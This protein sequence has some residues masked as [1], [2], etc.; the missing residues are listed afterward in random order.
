MK[1]NILYSLI[2][3]FWITSANTQELNCQ[4]SVTSDPALDVTT[5]EKEV[6]SQLEQTIFELVNT[7]AWTKDEFEVEER[8]NC[9]MVIS[10]IKV[11]SPGNYEATLQVQVSRPVFNTSYNTTLFN[12]LDENVQFSFERNAILVYS[13]NQFR[14]NLTSIIAFYAYMI[15]GYDYDSFALNGG[16]EHFR[17]AQEIVMLA[18]SGGGSGWR[19]NERG[20]K[21]RY[22]LVDNA[23]QELFSPLRECFYEYHRKGLDKM[24]DN[25]EEARNNMFAAIE[26]LSKV[27]TARPGSV[28]VLNF[29][30]AKVKEMK[31]IFS[32]APTKQKTDL[33]NILKRLDP[34]NSSK[35]QEIL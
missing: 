20:R 32:D 28:N 22:W 7:T 35:Y 10:V 4:V 33:V 26:K 12:F 14:N 21:N 1:I 23:L 18:Q 2:L 13:P 3:L 24:H 11:N 25:P 6:F 19:S 16:D 8:I 15:L 30:Q 27:N 9:N 29:L 5:V 31:G 17:K 34:S